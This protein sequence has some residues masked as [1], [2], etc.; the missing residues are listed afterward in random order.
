M[1][2]AFNLGDPKTMM[3]VSIHKDNASML[4]L[5]ETL[6]SQHTSCSK[7]YVIKTIWFWEQIVKSGIKLLKIEMV[8]QLGNMFTKALPKVIFAYL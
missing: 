1:S 7:H 2:A 6:P 8:K 5:A 4:I 3:Q